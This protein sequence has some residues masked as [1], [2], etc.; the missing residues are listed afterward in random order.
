MQRYLA[1]IIISFITFHSYSQD[2][3]C[4]P[5]RDIPNSQKAYKS[6]EKL[7]YIINYEWGMVKTDVGEAEAM[8]RMDR[9]ERYGE[10]FHAV[11]KGTTYKFYDIFFKVRDLFESRFNTVNGRPFYFNRDIAEGRYRMKNNNHYN[12]DYTINATVQRKS[13][14]AR[15]TLLKGTVC[16][17]DL[18]SLFY[19]AR[20]LD[21]SEVPA[22]VP[23]P[24]SFAIDDE[25]FNLYYKFLGRENKRIPGLGHFKTMKFAA[26]V[27]AGEV[28][29]G[30]EEI[31]LWVSDDA[32]MVPLLFETPI[33]VGKVTGRLSLF[34]NL[35]YPLSSKLK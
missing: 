2:K 8:L 9:N 18:V 1:L 21:F 15:D 33:M 22:G 7:V 11:V 30:K 19:F 12:K 17:F 27:V 34:D 23:Q 20:N 13:D 3:E 32:N 28:F 16:T 29:S 6:G 35:K 4:L 25:V 10:H 5:V 26:K 31:I 24:I 14:P